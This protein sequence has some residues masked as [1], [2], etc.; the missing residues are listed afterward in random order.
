MSTS[1]E[2]D[3][4]GPAD[5]ACRERARTG[6]GDVLRQGRGHAVAGGP[7]DAGVF[8]LRSLDAQI[9]ATRET[10]ATREDYLVIVDGAPTAASRRI[11]SQPGARRAFDAAAPA[12][13]PGAPAWLAEHLLGT[14]TAS[15]MLAL[16]QAIWHISGASRCRLPACHR[17]C[18]SRRR[19]FEP[20]RKTWRPPCPESALPSG[21]AAAYIL[22][23]YSAREQDLAALLT[24]S[25]RIWSIGPA[26]SLPISAA[27]VSPPSRSDDRGRSRRWR[28]IRNRSQTAFREVADALVN[29]EQTSATATD[30]QSSVD[31]ARNALRLATR[32]YEA[33]FAAYL[34]VLDAPTLAQH[35]AACAHPQPAGA[36]ICVRRPHE[37]ARWRWQDE[38]PARQMNRR[39]A[40]GHPPARLSS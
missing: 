17:R 31:A 15:S 14:L 33:G 24:S 32:R 1:F 30:L 35:R 20:P 18:S 2:I 23:G 12:E 21:A 7:H 40:E 29:V 11:S 34:N 26:L 38:Q 28:R 6:I 10:L 3:F 4:W 22:T 16:P 9:A 39:V 27:A 19:T 5:G 37:G 25:G 8:S 13:G 36:A